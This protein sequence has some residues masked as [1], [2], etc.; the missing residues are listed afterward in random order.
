VDA[1]PVLAWS[2]AALI[3]VLVTGNPSYRVLALAAALAVIARAVGLGRARRLLVGAAVLG[4]SAVALTFAVSHVGATAFFT[5]PDAV[6]AVGGPYTVEALAYGFVTGTTL[7]AAVLAAAPISLLLE[8][9]EVVDAL[10]RA[11]ARTG[12]AL[13]AA[14]NLVPGVARSF[15]A[16]V[17]AQRLRGWRP[18]GPSSWAEIVVPVVLTSIEDSI[19][20]AE[21]M[22]ARAF[23]SGPRTHLRRVRLGP[24]DWLVVAASGAAAAGFVAARVAGTVA[25]WYP[26][27]SLTWPEVSPLPI[28][29]C[30]LLAAPVLVWRLPPSPG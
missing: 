3:V 20:L 13:A 9:H 26:Y 23:G 29:A 6:P 12:G 30:L 19:Q 16:V 22:E 25:D 27:P 5:L 1:R 21:S 15:T 28:A 24:P 14:L 2:S 18:R 8:P 4:L 10:P 17:E 7:A 11:L